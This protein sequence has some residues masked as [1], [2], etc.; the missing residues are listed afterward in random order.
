MFY[1]LH[2]LHAVHQ[3]STWLTLLPPRH[4]QHVDTFLPSP[5][6]PLCLDCGQQ[7]CR[8]SSLSDVSLQPGSCCRLGALLLP[9]LQ[10]NL[11]HS[12]VYA[13]GATGTD[14]LLRWEKKTLSL[15]LK[16]LNCVNIS[17]R[18]STH[19]HASPSISQHLLP[20]A[21]FFPP[22]GHFSFPPLHFSPFVSSTALLLPH[23]LSLS[24][25]GVVS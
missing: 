11:R 16:S 18:L 20:L 1:S 25:A 9:P 21:V 5:S 13:G 19:P 7:P 10:S 3:Q 17:S 15:L 24:L 6:A 8:K 2:L 14:V 12:D 4:P 22:T 23:L